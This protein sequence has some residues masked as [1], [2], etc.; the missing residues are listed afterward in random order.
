M[1]LGSG[2]VDQI[3]SIAYVATEHACNSNYCNDQYV[4]ESGTILPEPPVFDPQIIPTPVINSASC[5]D[6]TTPGVDTDLC[7]QC[8]TCQKVTV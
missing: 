3:D 7:I 6:L 2:A 4:T 5:D 1:I 8:Y